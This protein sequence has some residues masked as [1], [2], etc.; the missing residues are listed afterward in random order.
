MSSEIETLKTALKASNAIISQQADELAKSA[1]EY[2]ELGELQKKDFMGY[3][4]ERD[5]L[6]GELLESKKFWEDALRNVT[7]DKDQQIATATAENARLNSL[8]V[9]KTLFGHQEATD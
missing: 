7:R 8:L 9:K 6:Q 2:F 5:K 3:R 4:A 1:Q